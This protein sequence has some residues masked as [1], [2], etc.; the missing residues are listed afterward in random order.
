MSAADRPVVLH[1]EDQLEPAA[2]FAAAAGLEARPIETRRF[3][4]GETLLRVPVPLPARVL[5]FCS[6]GQPDAR[7]VEVM[8]AAGAARDSGVARLALV[9]PYLC[10]MR[11][12]MAFRPGEAV[13]QRIVGRFLG[14]LFDAVVTVDPHLHRIDR[15]EQAI[16][17]GLPVALTAA[18]ALGAFVAANVP[19]AVLVGPDEESAQWAAAVASAAGRPHAVFAKVRHGDRD[20]DVV[21]DGGPSLAGRHVVLVDDIASSGRTLVQAARAC[22]AAG[23]VAV[24][25]VVTHALCAGDDLHA[26][27]EGGVE[28][29]WSTDSLPHPSNRVWL[30][31]LLARGCREHGLA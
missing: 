13:S 12:D 1:F 2:R 22:R 6:L 27:H 19:D 15:L 30:A 14:G 24:D 29:L 21:A 5:L 11:Q 23:A 16:P 17:S 9:A 25:A 26:L 4:D 28:R 10:Y 8:L 18:D 7:L 20:V 3:P 31:G